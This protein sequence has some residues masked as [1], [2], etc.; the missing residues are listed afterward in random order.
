MFL[1]RN[2]GSFL[3]TAP[4]NQELNSQQP[5]QVSTEPGQQLELHFNPSDLSQQLNQSQLPYILSI[6]THL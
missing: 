3:T 5:L 4:E 2:F 6:L 1:R